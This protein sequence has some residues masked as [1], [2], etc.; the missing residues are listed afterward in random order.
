RA[1]RGEGLLRAQHEAHA[2]VLPRVFGRARLCATGGGTNAGAQ[3]PQKQHRKSATSRGTNL[4]R[5]RRSV[6]DA[7]PWGH[8]L[9]LMERVKDGA[10]R[11][12]YLVHAVEQGWSRNT[13][14]LMIDGRAHERQGQ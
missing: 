12:W 10:Q 5:L 8:H 7:L 13:L 3:G 11:R 6:L 1:A 14:A 4:G 9:L 2:G